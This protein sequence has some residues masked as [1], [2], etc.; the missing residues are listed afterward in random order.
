MRA[1]AEKINSAL[2]FDADVYTYY[3]VGSTNDIAVEMAQTAQKTVVVVADCQ[4]DGK[5]RN[6]KS[7][8][9]PDETGLYMSVLTHPRSDFYSMNTVTCAA[10]VAVVRAIER[11]TDL[12]P[13]IKWVNDIYI[14]GRKVCGILCKAIGGNGKVEH[15]VTGI[16]VNITTDVF[17]D[18]I[19]NSAA[20]LERE[21][22]KNL[23]AAEIANELVLMT[24]YMDEYRE[25]SCV[26]GKKIT[27]FINGIAHDAETVGIDDS[28][29]LTVSDG[30]KEITLT[31]G[32]I[33]VRI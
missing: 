10:A 23:L 22:D 18:E 14:G 19:K 32:E 8:Y 28:G 5:G 33:T 7:F 31:G 3:K 13:E 30:E 29:G 24:D 17:P 20:S 1:E 12:K 6:G 4:T 27:Y 26:I 21:I 16:G 25:K 9:S 2:K 11:L 15:L